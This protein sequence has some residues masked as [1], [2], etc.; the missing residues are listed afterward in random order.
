[1]VSTVNTHKSFSVYCYISLL[2]VLFH[3]LDIATGEITRL[4]QCFGI[5]AYLCKYCKQ[6]VYMTKHQ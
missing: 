4:D 2:D 1:M 5:V 6:I 3:W